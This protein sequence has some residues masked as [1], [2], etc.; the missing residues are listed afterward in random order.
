MKIKCE[1]CDQFDYKGSFS[2]GDHDCISLLKD[3]ISLIQGPSTDRC[4]D[5][6]DVKSTARLRSGD[7]RPRALEDFK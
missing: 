2:N 6:V 5:E 7:Q 4:E 3:A 1:K